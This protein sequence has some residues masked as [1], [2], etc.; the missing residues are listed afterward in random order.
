[1]CHRINE[2]KFSWLEYSSSPELR[3]WPRNYYPKLLIRVA[4]AS[5]IVVTKLLFFAIFWKIE[6]ALENL[7]DS[8]L[9][10]QG[11]S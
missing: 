11:L 9:T 8:N 10:I 7:Q 6:E 5:P 3:R 4:E 2:E 1:M